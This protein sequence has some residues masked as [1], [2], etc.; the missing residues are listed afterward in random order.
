[1]AKKKVI[2][3]SPSNH[4][5]GQ[6]KCRKANCYEDKH[7]KPIA[8]KADKLFEKS[9]FKSIVADDDTGILNGA[10]TREANNAG[11]DLYIAY[12]TNAFSNKKT[13][14]L[15]FMCYRTDGE[16]RK[17][18]NCVKK[19]MEKIYDGDIIFKAVDD[20]VEITEP[21]A[22]TF[23]CEFG[24]HTN[25]EDCDN[26]IHNPDAI[27]EA[28]VKGVCDYYGVK[29]KGGKSTDKKPE[30]K[31][32]QKPAPE[33]KKVVDEDGLWGV[34]TT[35]YTQKLFGTYRDGVVSSQLYS[36]KEYLPNMLETSWEF[37]YVARGGSPMV[38]KLQKLVGSKAD[39]YA[40]KDTMKD[41]QSFLK[42][43]GLYSGKID[44]IGGSGTVTG[45]QKY[46]NK[47]LA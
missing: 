14:Y 1:M 21:N 38:E 41:L 3:N 32:A 28:L 7:T 27:A 15:L 45:W 5:V 23:Y 2:Y 4:G 46:L 25:K 10:R 8:L 40:G 36:C 12:H 18:F 22:M 17:L 34:D 24:F 42:S 31:P 30:P 6:N 37:G 43:Q 35:K 33:K 26:F 39:G 16:Y 20:L 9:G 19:Y 47:K 13:R 44:G 29:F 11:A